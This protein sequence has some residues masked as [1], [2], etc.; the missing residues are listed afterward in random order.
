MRYKEDV[1]YLVKHKESS[2]YDVVIIY[3]NS[4]FVSYKDDW[5]PDSSIQA[6]ENDYIVIGECPQ[7]ENIM[8]ANIITIEGN[9]GKGLG[10]LPQT[11]CSRSDWNI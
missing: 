11:I 2:L 3:K 8:K 4:D 9:N 6:L 1:E 10:N 7:I 5:M